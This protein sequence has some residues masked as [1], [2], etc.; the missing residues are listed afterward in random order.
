[1]LPM[2]K[3]LI[4]LTLISKLSFGQTL[5]LDSCGTD[6]YP[7]LTANE[8]VYFNQLF[9]KQRLDTQFD[10][11]GKKIGFAYGNFGKEIISKKDYFEKW[12]K[13]Y[14]KDKKLITNQ[15]IILSEKEKIASG[16]LD[17]IIVSWSKIKLSEKD[18]Q[19]LIN[20]LAK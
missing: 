1:M 12:G 11:D 5:I 17:A 8:V 9:E 6:S 13:T 10:F 3:L 2:K 15:L 16:G 20:K 14:L 18:K 7:L 19:N 4:L